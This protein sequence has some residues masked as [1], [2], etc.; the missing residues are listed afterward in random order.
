M[1]SPSPSRMYRYAG[2]LREQLPEAVGYSRPNELL[3][4]VCDITV[5]PF[6][7]DRDRGGNGT[8]G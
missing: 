3:E 5:I 1:P 8:G 6:A 7:P 4:G 2:W